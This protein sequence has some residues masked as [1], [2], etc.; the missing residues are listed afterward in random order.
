MDF[1]LSISPVFRIL[2]VFVLILVLCRARLPLG[3]ALV[4]GGLGIDLWAGKNLPAVLA[5]FGSALGQPELWLLVINIVLILEIGYFMATERNSR[6]ILAASRRLGGRNSRALSLVL[7]PAAIGLVPMPGGALF[8]APLVGE[9]IRGKEVPAAWKAAVNYWFRHV[10][11]YWWPLYPVVI[12]TLS[13]FHIGTWQFF[14]LQ[15]TF[16]FVCLAA[17]WF[18]LLRRRLDLLADDVRPETKDGASLS[19]VLLPIFIVVIATLLLPGPAGRLVPAASATLDKLLSMFAG[20]VLSLLLIAWQGRGDKDVRLFRNLAS[21]KTLN[22]VF[23]LGGVMIF[24]AM[25]GASGLLPEAGRQ[26]GNSFVPVE[27]VIAFLPFL[28]GLVTGIAIGF[29]G[30]SFPVVVGLAAATHLS[31]ASTL[32]LA[33]SMGYAGM[34]LSPMHLCYI[35]TLRYF[36]ARMAS[37]Y[38]YLLPCVLTVAAWGILMHLFLRFMGW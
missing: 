25:L 5:D 14:A 36:H 13:I 8:S 10:F 3:I 15:I 18:F 23:T 20:L 6:A 1:F 37:A 7:I 19:T 28:A 9:T 24:Q 16:T 22:V 31:Q 38:A 4:L 17:G 26:L 27:V 33:F 32:V 35:L 30:P 2:V 34:M 21:D 12:V 11:E 29:A